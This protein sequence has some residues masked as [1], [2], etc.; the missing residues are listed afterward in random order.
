LSEPMAT[1]LVP[2]A[3]TIEVRLLKEGRLERTA[4]LAEGSI[5]PSQFAGVSV[6]VPTVF[7]E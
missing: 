5:Q 3:E 6:A 2:E 4:I 1:A 7:P